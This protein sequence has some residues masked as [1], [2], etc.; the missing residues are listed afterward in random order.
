MKISNSTPNYINQTYANQANNVANQ[1]QKVEK[2]AE[3]GVADSINLSNRT[4]DLQ[5]VSQ[6][7]ETDTADRA[8][9]VADLKQSV[10]SNQY[11]VD[12]DK[13]AEKIAGTIMDEIA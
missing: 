8:K 2:P 1:N 3:E 13:V 4:K 9:L 6:A 7:L 11:S 10:E 12:V 5:K